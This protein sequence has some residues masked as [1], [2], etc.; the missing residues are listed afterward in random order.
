VK[1][2]SSLSNSSNT[3]AN[4]NPWVASRK[5]VDKFENVET[6]G[7]I[8]HS[9]CLG[10]LSV[11]PDLELPLFLTENVHCDKLISLYLKANRPACAARVAL[12]E[13]ELYSR[14]SAM[15]RV[16]HNAVWLPMDAFHEVQIALDDDAFSNKKK[17]ISGALRIAIDSHRNQLEKDAKTL[18]QVHQMY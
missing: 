15:K 17:H 13:L 6:N 1:V 11:N 16:K 12:K 3:L 8:A 18:A 10:A 5:I 9:A 2:S 7:M 14:A 4:E